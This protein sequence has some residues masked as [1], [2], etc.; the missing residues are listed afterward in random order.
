MK[1]DSLL[2]K[3]LLD[4]VLQMDGFRSNGIHSP[5]NRICGHRLGHD[6]FEAL[7]EVPT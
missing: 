3:V 2:G 5:V 1:L 6:L 7:F 4:Q